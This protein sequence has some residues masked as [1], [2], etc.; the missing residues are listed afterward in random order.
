MSNRGSHIGPRGNSNPAALSNWV[1][2]ADLPPHPGFGLRRPPPPLAALRRRQ[3]WR[4][5][6]PNRATGTGNRA[7]GDG[8]RATIAEDADGSVILDVAR[9]EDPWA[10]RR[11]ALRGHLGRARDFA[12]RIETGRVDNAADL[13]AREGLTRARVSQLLRLLKLAPA[14]LADLEDVDG[15]GPVPTEAALRKLAGIKTAERQV[16]EYRRLCGAEAAGRPPQ[17]PVRRG[18]PPQRGLQHL[19][20]RARRYHALLEAGEHRSLNELGR[21]EGVTGNRVAQVLRLLQLDPE[22]IAQVDVAPGELPEGITEKKLRRVA[23]LRSRGEQLAAWA[24][25][26]GGEEARAAK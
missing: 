1:I 11:T 4:D 22:I 16:Y 2:E 5:S 19:F 23:G 6:D 14:I 18:R 12:R 20:E 13:A 26:T 8:D 17:A 9:F 3:A 21:A 25:L 7:I 24:A 15:T 10:S